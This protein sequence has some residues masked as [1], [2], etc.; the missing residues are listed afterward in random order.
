M[1][2][3]IAAAA[4]IGVLLAEPLAAYEQ[5]LRDYSIREAYFLG[6]RKDEKA[7][8]FLAQY[9]KKLP[10]PKEGPHVAEIELRTP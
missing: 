3:P 10:V 2:S 1:R 9:V 8:Q 5:P 6:R 4:L 7:A